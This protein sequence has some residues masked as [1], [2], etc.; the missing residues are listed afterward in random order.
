MLFCPPLLSNPCL[1]KVAL[2]KPGKRSYERY[3]ARAVAQ[4]VLGRRNKDRVT[5]N[6][7]SQETF[8]LQEDILNVLSQMGALG[9]KRGSNFL[10]RKRAIREWLVK[11]NLDVKPPIDPDKFCLPPSSCASEVEFEDDQDEEE[12]SENSS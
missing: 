1:I 2:S 9:A 6:M 10:L 11:A 3:W 5:V 4:Y 7:L 12:Q 8:I